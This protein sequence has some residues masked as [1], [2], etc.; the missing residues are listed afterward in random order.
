M[1]RRKGF[2]LL[3]LIAV[4]IILGIV[5]I[6]GGMFLADFVN[7]YMLSAGNAE[8]ASK[9]QVALDRM[10]LELKDMQT[11]ASDP[12]GGSIITYTRDEPAGTI[13]CVI[14]YNNTNNEIQLSVDGGATYRTL[15]DEVQNVSITATYQNI[16]GSSG[17]GGKQEVAFINIFFNVEN[18]STSFQTRIFPRYMVA[19]P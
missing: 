6:L 13:N 9:C 8:R 18:I 15:L 7:A 2:T 4:L 17:S 5:A 11:L 1:K 14:S 3:E 12:V 19:Q 16:D 10:S